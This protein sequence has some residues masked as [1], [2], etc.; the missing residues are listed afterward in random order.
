[1]SLGF[2]SYT[3]YKALPVA[4]LLVSEYN[5]NLPLL[6]DMLKTGGFNNLLFISSNAFSC[7][8][9]Q[10]NSLAFFVNS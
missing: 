7:S 2:P 4:N 3:W 6:S 10:T 5:K 1:M 9:P 8:P